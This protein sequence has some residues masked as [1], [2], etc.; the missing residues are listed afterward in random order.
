M[1]ETDPCLGLCWW[2]LCSLQVLGRRVGWCVFLFWRSLLGATS[3]SSFRLKIV[4]MKRGRHHHLIM[5]ELEG[6]A[7]PAT[8]YVL[9][10]R[11]CHGCSR[12]QYG[13]EQVSP[14]SIDR[15][16]GR[17]Q[18]QTHHHL[19]FRE[20]EGFAHPTTGFVRQV[21][22]CH[23]GHGRSRSHFGA[24]QVSPCSVDLVRHWPL[25]S[26]DLAVSTVPT[27]EGP[28]LDWKAIGLSNK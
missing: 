8:G 11:G 7:L 23:R 15:S 17:G 14:C 5:R 25:A 26:L 19:V 28:L 12:S 2:L 1:K 20:L 22:G 16:C 24:E 3:G 21:R 9:Q 27:D 18:T 13:A 6:F 4:L 10:V